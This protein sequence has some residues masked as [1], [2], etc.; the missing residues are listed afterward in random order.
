MKSRITEAVILSLGIIIMGMSLRAGINDFK[1]KERTV[2]VKGLSVKEVKADKVVWP[3]IYKLLGNNIPSLYDQIQSQNAKILQFLKE[4]GISDEEISINPPKII[5]LN[6]D[7]YNQNKTGFRYNSTSV[8]IVTSSKVDLVRKLI[9]EQGELLKKG[10]VITGGDYQY[11][12]AYGFTRLNEIKPEMI[13]EATKNARAT[14]EKFA[15][16]S[17][18]KLGKIK[19]AS[20]GQFSISDRDSYTPYIKKIR[21]V[22]SIQYYLKK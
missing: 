13:E 14:A 20:Q 6:A 4:K 2:S 22:S 10:V 18:S 17:D 19:Y 8:I 9:A 3:L 5:D 16:D 7:R 21:V 1:D 11:N 12:I 15:R